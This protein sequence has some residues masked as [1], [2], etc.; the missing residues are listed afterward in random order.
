M[1]GLDSARLSLPVALLDHFSALKDPR[2]AWKVLYPLPEILPTVLCATMEGAEDFADVERWAKR[3]LDFLRRFLPFERGVP[4][5][6]TLNEVMNALPAGLF[7]DCFVSFVASPRDKNPDI[8][9]IPG[10][11]PGVGKSSR[12]AH[13]AGGGRRASASCSASR[14]WRA[15][16]TRSSPSRACWSGWS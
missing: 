9:A 5:H 2:Q 10:S 8:V 4:S 3:K 14:R 15:R 7:S 12:R 13:A 1:G 6:D 16:A 11:S